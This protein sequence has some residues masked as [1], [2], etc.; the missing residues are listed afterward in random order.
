MSEFNTRYED[1]KRYA[2]EN[3]YEQLNKLKASMEEFNEMAEA[4]EVDPNRFM[5]RIMCFSR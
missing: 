3:D 5:N 1:V 4:E 2:G